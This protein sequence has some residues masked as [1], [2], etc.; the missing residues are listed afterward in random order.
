VLLNQH[1]LLPDDAELDAV[2]VLEG[3]SRVV[4]RRQQGIAGESRV[5]EGWGRVLRESG[6]GF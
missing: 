6:A 2:R 3:G 5:S 4:E 1:D